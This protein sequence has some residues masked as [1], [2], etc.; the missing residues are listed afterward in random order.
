MVCFEYMGVCAFMNMH[1]CVCM[2]LWMHRCVFIYEYMGV[3]A[4]LNRWV[5]MVFRLHGLG[6][7]FSFFNT[8][9]P[10]SMSEH[11]NL[12]CLY[13]MVEMW[14]WISIVWVLVFHV[15]HFFR[16]LKLMMRVLFHRKQVSLV[17]LSVQHLID[18]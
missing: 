1:V 4:F 6:F 16:N 8:F 2:S 10:F 18:L 12:S 11:I 17:P 9:A 3:C 5:C 7:F 15:C 13:C 14:I